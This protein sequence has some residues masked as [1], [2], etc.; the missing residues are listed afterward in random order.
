MSPW[1]RVCC[2]TRQ[3]D[4]AARPSLPETTAWIGCELLSPCHKQAES[5]EVPKGIEFGKVKSSQSSGFVWR[6]DASYNARFFGIISQPKSQAFFD[7]WPF[8]EGDG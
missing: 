1:R 4:S 5:F 6:F 7:F 2:F 3:C 8:L